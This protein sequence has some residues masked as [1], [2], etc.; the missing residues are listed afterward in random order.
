MSPFR[1]A[2]H[3]FAV[4]V[5]VLGLAS[6]TVALT[7]AEGGRFA[8]TLQDGTPGA[9]P[10]DDC[11]DDDDDEG[12][13]EA[14][15]SADDDDN[16]EDEDESGDRDEEDDEDEDRDDDDGEDDD[17]RDADDEDDDD[18]D[19]DNHRDDDCEDETGAPG[20]LVQG[21]EL[22]P[23]A[24]VSL[25]EAIAIAQAE[26]DGELGTVEL[27]EEDGTL[28][29]EVHIGDHEVVIDATTGEVIEVEEDDD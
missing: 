27:E 23:Q 18:S 13:P 1:Y 11:V 24:T 6:A 20:E 5:L 10:P 3:L 15:A 9:T 22:L 7:Q 8:V 26:V 17:D 14:S 16:G 28:V 25:D 12:T 21:E 4:V 2:R 19:N 29:Y